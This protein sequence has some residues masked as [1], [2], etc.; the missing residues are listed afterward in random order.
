MA[1]WWEHIQPSNTPSPMPC[2]EVTRGQLWC[3]HP[4]C[5][6][7]FAPPL[8]RNFSPSVPLV[9]GRLGTM[10]PGLLGGL[11]RVTWIDNSVLLGWS[12]SFSLSTENGGARLSLAGAHPQ[13]RQTSVFP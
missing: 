6:G 3:F 1:F 7:D 2:Q 5:G 10:A 13:V 4:W 8:G 9:I 11:Q 12:L